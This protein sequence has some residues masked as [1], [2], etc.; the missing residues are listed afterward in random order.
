MQYWDQLIQAAMLGTGKQPINIAAPEG[1][2]KD[3]LEAIAANGGIDAEERFLQQ[4]T[5]TSGYRQSGFEPLHREAV[6][7]TVAEKEEYPYCSPAAVQALNDILEEDSSSLLKLWLQL[8]RQKRQLV[9]PALLPA[10]FDKVTTQKKLRTLA[11]T[12]AGRRGAW[13]AAFNKDWAF[14][15]APSD[16]ET[17]QTGSMD[18]RKEVLER[19]RATEPARALE[20]L[21]R[22]WG[23][24]NAAGKT[25]LLKALYTGLSGQDVPWLESIL[26]EKSQKVK[27]E[28]VSLLKRVSSSSIVQRNESVL[29]QAVQLKKEKALLGL[30]SKTSLQ[31]Q[32]PATI[33]EAIYKTG[34]E[35]L[36]NRKEFA[37]EEFIIYQLMQAVPP[38]FWETQL[39]IKPDEIIELFQKEEA[40]KK[41][42]AALVV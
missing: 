19:L 22:T 42:M 27:D 15:S 25:E 30:S 8:C 11:Q 12:C 29:R 38:S 18:Q 5:L 24:E 40:T 39:G 35:K 10:L 2:L 37:D 17:W 31:I 26:T 9:P 36:S 23:E 16:E 20:W 41:Y 1:A 34:I 3:A 33:D 13:L 6:V 32:L 14:S 4:M 28:T 7:T 21:Q